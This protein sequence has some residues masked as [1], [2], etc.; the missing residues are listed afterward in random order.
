M[1]NVSF[2]ALGGMN[3]QG[4]NLYFLEIDKN[5]FIINSGSKMPNFNG[6]GVDL[7]I[8]DI[9][10]LERNIKHVKGIFITNGELENIG[11]LPYI[12]KKLPQVPIYANQYAQNTI[13]N[14]FLKFRIKKFNLQ[15]LRNEL[16]FNDIIVKTFFANYSFP[17]NL[18][19]SFIKNNSQII[20][21][22]DFYFQK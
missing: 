9:L 10:Y 2:L 15:P 1:K 8:P 12:V 13:Q 16:K 21:L 17:L 19:L 5:I 3:E 22:G 20:Y 14:L 6:F 4:K 18:G 7:I 11:S